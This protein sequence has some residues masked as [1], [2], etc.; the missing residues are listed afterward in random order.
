MA[1]DARHISHRV[2]YIDALNR[3]WWRNRKPA[4]MAITLPT[5]SI[6]AKLVISRNNNTH[7][8]F[9]GIGQGAKG[10]PNFWKKENKGVLNKHTI[11]V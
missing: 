6:L 9:R 8:V 3:Q 11:K 2:S 5:P 4:N 1:V 10:D 7:P